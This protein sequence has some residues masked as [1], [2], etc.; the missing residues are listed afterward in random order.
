MPKKNSNLELTKYYN[1]AN[2]AIDYLIRENAFSIIYDDYNPILEYYEKKKNHL[3]TYLQKRQLSKI[4]QVFN[5]ILLRRQRA[6]DFDFNTYIK[7]KTGYNFDIFESLIIR[8]DIVIQQKRINNK[9]EEFDVVAALN[10]YRKT[11]GYQAKIEILH[12]LLVNYSLPAIN[13]FVNNLDNTKIISE[14]SLPNGKRI[15]IEFK[16][17][18]NKNLISEINSPNGR[19]K[20][21]ILKSSKDLNKALTF[22]IVHFDKVSG[23]IFTLKGFQPEVNAYWLDN[24]NIEIMY[25][26]NTNIIDKINRVKRFENEISIKYIEF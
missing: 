18:I 23:S 24:N 15:T 6:V 10:F 25:K 5:L 26:R 9:E 16:G 12:L 19:Y 1:L 11:S 21:E 8:S 20:I 4:K 3:N 2:V 13:A 22:V 14:T 7:E 17:S